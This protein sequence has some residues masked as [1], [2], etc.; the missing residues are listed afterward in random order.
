MVVNA[1][2]TELMYFKRDDLKVN[3]DGCLLE[4]R[5]EM[6]VLGITFDQS[7]C[8]EPQLKRAFNG[9]QRFKPALRYLRTK[10]K[11]KEFLQ[12]VSSHY[13]SRLYYG[14]EI[15]FDCLK[16]KF[17]DSISPVHFYPLRLAMFDF[18][19][20]YSRK[21]LCHL[22]KRASPQELNNYKIAKT[23]ISISENAEPFVLFNEV[24]SHS[25]IERR[26]QFNPT[27][28]DMSRTRIGRQSFANRLNFVARKLCF[29]W[30]GIMLSKSAV[31]VNLKRAF[32]AY[33]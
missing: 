31:R 17:R 27:F 30:L 16:A 32:F 15:W 21:N 25:V 10:L 2:K 12:V 22:T 26:R 9:C 6:N 18:K 33:I 7:L 19:K 11:K 24:L 28:L 5:S 23:L 8:W 20:K 13:Y 1:S 4:S 14:S 29:E 3:I